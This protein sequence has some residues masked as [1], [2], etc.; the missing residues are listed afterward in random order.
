MMGP[1]LPIDAVSGGDLAGRHDTITIGQDAS[2]DSDLPR[3]LD[4]GVLPEYVIEPPDILTLETIN[5]VPKAPYTLRT[6]DSISIEVTGT[7]PDAP[8]AAVFPI[9]IGG[10]VDLHAGQRS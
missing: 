9:A 2:K 5:A 8:I 3:E 4:K 7:L 10:L 6:L 1:A